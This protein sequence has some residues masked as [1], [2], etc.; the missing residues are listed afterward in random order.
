M[1]MIF[2]L[3]PMCYT[4]LR[5]SSPV[6][7]R[8]EELPGHTPSHGRVLRQRHKRGVRPVGVANG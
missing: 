8:T 1:K 4:K 5:L 6:L 7:A 3:K 2:K